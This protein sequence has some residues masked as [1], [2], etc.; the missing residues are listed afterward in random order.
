ML[1]IEKAFDGQT[2]TIRLIGRLQS[3]HLAELTKQLERPRS[4]LDLDE[5]TLADVEVVRFLNACE[6]EG[7]SLLHCPR[8]IREWMRRENSELDKIEAPTIQ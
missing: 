3:E 8:Y 1:R 6:Q 2:T 5:L 4:V 7:V